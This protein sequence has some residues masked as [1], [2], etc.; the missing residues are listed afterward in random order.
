LEERGCVGA[1]ESFVAFND[2]LEVGL[3]GHWIK[4]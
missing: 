1:G 4:G 3:Q 2:S